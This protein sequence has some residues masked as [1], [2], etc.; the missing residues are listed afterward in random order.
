M[1][2]ARS[3]RPAFAPAKRPKRRNITAGALAALGVRTGL[4]HTELKLT[5][6][7][8]RIIEVNGRLGGFVEDL[9]SSHGN[10]SLITLA[11]AVALAIN[12]E[13][14]DFTGE[15]PVVFNFSNLPPLDARQL[16][17]VGRSASGPSP[18]G[19]AL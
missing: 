7:G 12:A 4:T 14:P 18:A 10:G 11:C 15:K 1:R 19:A 9:A 5:E 6:W 3:G 17:G 13:I 8:P 16:I 2:L